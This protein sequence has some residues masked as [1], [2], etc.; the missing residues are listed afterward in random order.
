MTEYLSD[1]LQK[2]LRSIGL[3]TETEVAAKQGD[4]YI[5]VS[6][7]NDARRVIHVDNTLLLE[8]NK[9]ILRG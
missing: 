2:K 7:I 6:V 1:D 8:E 5:A 3:I 4:V 9:R